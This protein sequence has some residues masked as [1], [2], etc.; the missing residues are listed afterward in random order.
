MVKPMKRFKILFCILCTFLLIG[1]SKNT[2]TD[3][4]KTDIENKS[5]STNQIEKIDNNKNDEFADLDL[6]N[7]PDPYHMSKEEFDNLSISDIRKIAA[8]YI[9][10]YRQT[11][12]IDSNKKMTDSDWESIKSIMRYQLFGAEINTELSEEEKEELVKSTISENEIQYV[13]PKA[14]DLKK[15]STQE[16]ALWFN[17]ACKYYAKGNYNAEC[18]DLTKLTDEQIKEVQDKF[19]KGL[20]NE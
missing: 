11:Y 17:E 14:E 2:K 20:Q 9:T 16:F 6:T 5:V 1:C 7:C 3:I 19:V 13:F 8:V 18:I 10:D 15:M 12:K 4:V